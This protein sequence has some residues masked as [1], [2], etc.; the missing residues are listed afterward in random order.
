MKVLRGALNISG[1]ANGYGEREQQI[2][3]LD[4][5]E[6]L[7]ENAVTGQK[8]LIDIATLRAPRKHSTAR[9][10]ASSTE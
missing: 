2:H 9:R 6:A 5:E 8:F 10:R 1:D 3:W 7:Q 4:A